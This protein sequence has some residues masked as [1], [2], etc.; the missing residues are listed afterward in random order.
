MAK[1]VTKVIAKMLEKYVDIAEA[2][3]ILPANTCVPC[4]IKWAMKEIS[5]K[6]VHIA[7]AFLIC[8]QGIDVQDAEKRV[9]KVGVAQAVHIAEVPL[10]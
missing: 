1:R 5:A 8:H 3:N 7:E 2:V 10:M 4:V 9:T 6:D